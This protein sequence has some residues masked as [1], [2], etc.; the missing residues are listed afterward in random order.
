MTM[1]MP[2]MNKLTILVVLTNFVRNR[3]GVA[4]VDG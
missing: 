4:N 1:I 3:D 2:V